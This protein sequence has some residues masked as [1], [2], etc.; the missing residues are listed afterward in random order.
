MRPAAPEPPPPHQKNL[1]ITPVPVAWVCS[2]RTPRRWD[3]WPGGTA[4][5][6]AGHQ[7]GRS[8]SSPGTTAARQQL[9][10]ER[11]SKR[12]K[13]RFGFQRIRK[14]G[15]DPPDLLISTVVS[16]QAGLALTQLRVGS[17]QSDTSSPGKLGPG[18]KRRQTH[19]RATVKSFPCRLGF[20]RPG[21]QSN[22]PARLC[23]YPSF[24]PETVLKEYYELQLPWHALFLLQVPA[25]FSAQ[26]GWC[27]ADAQLFGILF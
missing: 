7:P 10:A 2:K 24:L 25:L 3:I 21:L 20:A 1:P 19:H 11:E 27:P 5:A 13:S 26:N 8:G 18:P 23:K 14:K 12:R 22:T 15:L 4:R 16:P 9:K 17:I 6:T